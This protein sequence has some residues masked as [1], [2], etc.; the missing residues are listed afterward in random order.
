MVSV[1]LALVVLVPFLFTLG[2]RVDKC[3]RGSMGGVPGLTS[4]STL[5]GIR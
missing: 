4:P 1:L 3:G 5:F 2:S